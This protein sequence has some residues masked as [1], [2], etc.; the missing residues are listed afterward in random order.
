MRLST[1]LLLIFCWSL[2]GAAAAGAQEGR[3]SFIVAGR[4]IQPD[5]NAAGRAMVKITGQSGM[6]QQVFTDDMGRFEFAN[7]PRGRYYLTAENPSAKEQF[8]DPVELDL[9]RGLSN[10]VSVN[11]FLRNNAATTSSKKERPGVVSVAE[12]TQEVPKPARKAYEQAL[13]LRGDR[14]YEESLKSFGRSIELFPSY[15]QALAER[16]HLLIAMGRAAE[17]AEDFAH[18]LDLNMRYGPALRGSGMCKFQQGKYAE[19][20]EDLERAAEA[21]PGNATIYLFMGTSYLALDRRQQ[22][23]SALQKALSIDAAGAARAHVHL[24]NL[25]I[26]ENRLQDA[27]AEIDLYLHV[28]PNAPDADKLRDLAAQLRASV[29]KNDE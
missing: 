9:G 16:G 26:K 24:A 4:V 21:E 13:R 7:V 15:F 29:N 17:A 14:Q 2:C 18:A 25:C 3:V 8:T 6:N 20:A 23:R 12:A 10:R 28:V 27:L 1:R 5:G 11:I 19:A 22:A